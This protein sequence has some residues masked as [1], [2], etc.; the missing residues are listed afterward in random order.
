MSGVFQNIDPPPPT[1]SPPGECVKRGVGGV[2][3]LEDARHSSVLY[4][5]K[6]FVITTILYLSY[7]MFIK[8]VPDPLG[9]FPAAASLDAPVPRD[10][11]HSGRPRAARGS[12]QC[13]IFIKKFH[14][15][16]IKIRDHR[17]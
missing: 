1:P 5:Y 16:I 2:N 11:S 10:P 3:I 17:V 14:Q 8:Y 6:Y 15:I 13:I 7:M 9:P 12:C 4:I